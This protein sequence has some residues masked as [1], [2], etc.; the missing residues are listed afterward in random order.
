M[1]PLW[2]FSCALMLLEFY[3]IQLGSL[4]PIAFGHWKHYAIIILGAEFIFLPLPHLY[5]AVADK[6]PGDICPDSSECMGSV[7]GKSSPQSPCCAPFGW[8]DR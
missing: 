4:K 2:L 8:S 3:R 6:E 1:L 7:L 5:Y